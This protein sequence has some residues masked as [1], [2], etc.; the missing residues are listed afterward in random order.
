MTKIK[1]R[2]YKV[3]LFPHLI[4]KLSEL[5]SRVPIICVSREDR[6]EVIIV[7]PRSIDNCLRVAQE[8]HGILIDLANRGERRDETT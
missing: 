8:V 1:Q 7:F 5:I 6:C 4:R 3:P 2:I